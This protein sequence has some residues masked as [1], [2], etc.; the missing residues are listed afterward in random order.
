MR[1]Q[2]YHLPMAGLM[3]IAVVGLTLL[4]RPPSTT[5]FAQAYSPQNYEEM[6][7]TVE[8]IGQEPIQPLPSNI[9]WP[10]EQVELGKHLFN[11]TN[12]SRNQQMS[13]ATCHL[14]QSG[15]DDGLPVAIDVE[16]LP[17]DFN[18]P[19]V[20]NS[21]FNFRQFW[22][23]RATSLEEQMAETLLNPRE[24]GSSWESALSFLR[25]NRSYQQAFQKAYDG[26]ISKATVSHAIAT[27]Q[28]SLI[29]PSPFDAYLRGD[30]Q[31]ISADAKL[32]YQHFKNYG[33]I[34]C[35][36]GVNIGGNIFQPFGA[37]RK[38]RSFFGLNGN[39]VTGEESGSDGSRSDIFQKEMLQHGPSS[40]H[41][42]VPS[43]RNVALTA[44]Y[45]HNG[46]ISNLQDVIQMMAS[47]QLDRTIAPEHVHQI[48]AFLNSLTGHLPGEQVGEQDV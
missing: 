7:A 6:I 14:L 17:M 30:Q 24:M 12:L 29:T 10:P 15:G 39:T 41:F 16:Q 4:F 47:A 19:T 11:E 43:L 13:C 31:A 25:N 5:D 44:P 32:G 46:N 27:F 42:K 1:R 21:G 35:H 37:I 20:L 26:N 45:L 23:G 28:R 9:Q 40:E 18:T 48:E 34:A 22:N 38:Y 33:C 8:T 36:Q 3:A 2:W